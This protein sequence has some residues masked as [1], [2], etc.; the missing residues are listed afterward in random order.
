MR[1]ANE[2]T[3]FI[4]RESVRCFADRPKP[5]YHGFLPLVCIDASLYSRYRVGI[6]FFLF[7]MFFPLACFSSC[8]HQ[9]CNIRK[10]NKKIKTYDRRARCRI[11]FSPFRKNRF[12]TSPNIF[13]KIRRIYYNNN[14]NNDNDNCFSIS[15]VYIK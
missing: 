11:L 1:G 10:K 2:R 8:G 3:V 12:H 15:R 9:F 7:S 13:H 5:G 4:Y 14:N 6:F